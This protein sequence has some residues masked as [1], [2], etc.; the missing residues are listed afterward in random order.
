MRSKGCA[1]L[2]IAAVDRALAL[3]AYTAA[4]HV[5]V[6]RHTSQETLALLGHAQLLIRHG[7]LEQSS[8][9]DLVRAL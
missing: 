5:G 3:L 4:A 7:L 2:G 1:Y 8:E 9:L 6:T